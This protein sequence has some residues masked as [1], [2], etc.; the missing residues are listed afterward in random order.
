M[1]RGDVVLVVWPYSDGSGA[2]SRPA[3]VI[4][5][6]FLN[7]RIADSVFIQITSRPRGIST[8]VLLDPV[9]EVSSGLRLVS[10]AVS[11]N[12]LTIDKG[13]VRRRLGELSAPAL[14]QIESAVKTALGLP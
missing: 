12:I 13:F 14:Q 4:Q 2:K 1:K 11:N 6:D 3:V 9:V 7:I 10:F 8:E 5:A